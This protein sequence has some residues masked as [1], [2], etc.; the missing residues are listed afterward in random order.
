M[1]NNDDF[2]EEDNLYERDPKRQEH[3]E[4]KVA[5]QQRKEEIPENIYLKE[6]LLDRV[7]WYKKWE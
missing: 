3:E 4:K 5:L 2:Q 1:K 6:H 7:A